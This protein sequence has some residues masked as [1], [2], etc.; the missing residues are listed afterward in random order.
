MGTRTAAIWLRLAVGRGT[1]LYGA[2]IRVE[3]AI[4]CFDPPPATG[5]MIFV[6]HTAQAEEENQGDQR[7]VLA[8]I[9]D[10][11]PAVLAVQGGWER[12]HE[13]ARYF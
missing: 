1:S 5:D 6:L 12:G 7:S 3:S 11:G 2:T 9:A 13:I 4:Y 10:K 8:A